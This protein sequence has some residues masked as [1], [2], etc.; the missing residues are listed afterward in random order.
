VMPATA[1]SVI[2]Y[3]PGGRREIFTDLKDIQ[4]RAYPIDPFRAAA[5]TCDAVVICNINF[6]RGFLAEAKRLGKLV[7]T[8]VHAISDLEDPFNQDFMAAADVLFMSHERLP[9][10][11]EMWAHAMLER[12]GMRLLVIGLGADGALLAVRDDHC[13]KHFPA[14]QTRQVINTVGAGD[15][16]FS[17]FLHAYLQTGDPYRAIQIATLFASWKIGVSGGADG[18]PTAAELHKLSED[19]YGGFQ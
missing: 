16:L 7:A 11:P 4:E 3:D 13:L 15:A 18:F 1:Q 19:Y 5:A 10:E 8:D 14:V 17:G 6:A 2:L 9:M 12:F